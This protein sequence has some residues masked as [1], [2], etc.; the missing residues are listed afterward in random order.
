MSPLARL[1]A[2]PYTGADQRGNRRL[3]T[4]V[5]AAVG[6]VVVPLVG[7]LLHVAPH[8]QQT[9]RQCSRILRPSTRSVDFRRLPRRFPYRGGVRIGTPL[10]PLQPH[11]PIKEHWPRRRVGSTPRRLVGSTA[12]GTIP[13]NEAP[14]TKKGEIAKRTPL[15]QSGPPSETRKKAH[16]S[17]PARWTA[18]PSRR[19]AATAFDARAISSAWF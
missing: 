11:T 13:P 7:V 6:A 8:V 1:A 9:A 5:V 16:K 2:G 10:A 12:A 17:P 15:S 19:R 3:K 4:G 18:P 14:C